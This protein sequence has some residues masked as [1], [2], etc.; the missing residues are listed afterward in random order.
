MTK[1]RKLRLLCAIVLGGMAFAL[2][3]HGLV[4][5]IFAVGWPSNTFLFGP[6]I[7]FSDFYDIFL[8]LQGGDPLGRVQAIYFPFA[9]LTLVPIVGLPANAALA[10]TFAVFAIGV[11][12]WCWRALPELPPLRRAAVASAT[13]F[14]TYPFLICIDRA[15]MEMIVALF[16]FGFLVA[17]QRGR[18]MLGAALLAGAIAMKVYP[19]VFGVILLQRRQYRAAALCAVLTIAFTLLP[20]A[21]FPGGIAQSFETLNGNQQ[22]FRDNFIFNPGRAYFSTSY[23]SVLKFGSRYVHADPQALLHA[24]HGVYIALSAALFA[25]LGWHVWRR[26]PVLWKQAA[27]LCFAMLVLPEVSFDYRLIHV[28]GPLMLFLA[29]PPEQ[30]RD[31]LFYT[32]G[33]GLLL[34]PKAYAP[35]GVETTIGVLINPALMTLMAAHIVWRRYGARPTIAAEAGTD[36]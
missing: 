28:L 20:A 29:A 10:I 8:P 17:L 12:W 2:A 25:V 27:L 24:L 16:V 11:F 15:N 7:R 31:D 32:I 30:G 6:S 9:Y 22:W 26:E 23:W 33:F 19:G 14:A 4:A 13:G 5:R 18:V 35:L 36:A 21:F 3:Y 34:I 1:T